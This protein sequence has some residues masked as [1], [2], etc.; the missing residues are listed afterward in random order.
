VRQV[1][2]VTGAGSGIGRAIVGRFAADGMTVVAVDRDPASLDEALADPWRSARSQIHPLIADVASTEDAVRMVA[3]AE[4]KLGRLDVLVNNA[5]I[6]GGAQATILHETPIEAWDAVFA[7]NVRGIFLGCRAALPG[8][9]ARGGGTIINI[10]SV[11]GLVAFPG[12]AAYTAS[13]GAVVALTR[14]LAVDY[15]ARGI[16]A[17]AICPGM[18]DTPMTRWR[19]ERP[20]LRAE[21]LARIPQRTIGSPDDVA[22]AVSFAAGPDAGYLNGSCLVVDGGYTA[23]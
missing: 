18:I 14:S 13:K 9:L 11:A 1:G 22:G 5:G 19:L 10:A 6:T 7:V 20:E 23:I 4:E 15:A 17:V 2:L 8:M 12:R 16:R 3:Y 21:V